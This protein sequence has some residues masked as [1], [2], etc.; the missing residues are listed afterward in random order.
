MHI[1]VAVHLLVLSLLYLVGSQ[2]VPSCPQRD[3]STLKF[4]FMT[5]FGS[6]FNTSGSVVAMM[7]ALERIN[8][9]STILADHT[10]EYSDIV[11]SQVWIITCN[12]Y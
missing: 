3:N 1:C 7:M 5:S 12:Y 11:D 9:N 6:A 2:D 8:A 10:L 4:L